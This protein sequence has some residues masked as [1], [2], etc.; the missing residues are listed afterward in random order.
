MV[1]SVDK[2]TA[3]KMYD[4]VKH[5]WDRKTQKNLYIE[6]SKAKSEEEKIK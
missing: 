5:Y 2:F 4:K 3:V 1:V 6:R